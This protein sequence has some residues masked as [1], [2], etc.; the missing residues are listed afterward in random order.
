LKLAE[1]D[2]QRRKRN[3]AFVNCYILCNASQTVREVEDSAIN[4]V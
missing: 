4:E 2:G 3:C 1:T